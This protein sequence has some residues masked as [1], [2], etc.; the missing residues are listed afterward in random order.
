MEIACSVNGVPIRLAAERWLH[1]VETHDEM[2]GRED[3]VLRT[4]ESPEVIT[5]GHRGAIV[6]W[7][8]FPARSWHD[9][10]SLRGPV[11]QLLVQRKGRTSA[12]SV[13]G[14]PGTAH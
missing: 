13:L 6:A 14:R 9:Q 12:I 2:A 10:V 8:W 11:Y 7:R 4:I 3:D 1:I 5:R